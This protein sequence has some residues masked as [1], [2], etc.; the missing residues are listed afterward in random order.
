MVALFCVGD[1]AIYTV[2]RFSVNLRERIS[3][4]DVK[5][6]GELCASWATCCST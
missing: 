5:G 3:C 2:H 4:C 6:P 1:V